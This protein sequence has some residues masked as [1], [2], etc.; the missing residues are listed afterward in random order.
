MGRCAGLWQGRR[1]GKRDG[2]AAQ[3]PNELALHCTSLLLPAFRTTGLGIA[4]RRV[5]DIF[6]TLRERGCLVEQTIEQLYSEPLGK[7][8]ADR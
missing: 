8:L 2:L 4:S 6:R 5:Q 1:S 3:R 7:F